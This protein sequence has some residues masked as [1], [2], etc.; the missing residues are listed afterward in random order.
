MGGLRK[1]RSRSPLGPGARW[2]LRTLLDQMDAL[3][4]EIT[5]LDQAM[6][7][8]SRSARY[9]AG[10]EALE[11]ISGVGLLTAMV[12]LTEMGDLKRFSNRRQVAA[13]LEVVPSSNESGETA[14]RKGHITRQGSDRGRSVLCQAAWS[15]I[16]RN[17]AIRNMYRRLLVK[18]PK[19]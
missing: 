6:Q 19:K 4:D 17:P 10:V 14:D 13:Y 12:F 1:Q 16:N 18:N 2:A 9:A 15:A 5:E 8:L 7:A 11:Q 3:E